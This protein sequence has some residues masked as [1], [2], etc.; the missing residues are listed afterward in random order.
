MLFQSTLEGLKIAVPVF[1]MEESN[2]DLLLGCPWEWMAWATFINED[3]GS[4]TCRIKS[5]DG[6]RIVQFT[7]AKAD[8]QRNRSFVRDAD[9]SFPTQHLKA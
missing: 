2:Q 4:Y 6:R 9:G 7:A 3:D 8:H 5:L 1:I